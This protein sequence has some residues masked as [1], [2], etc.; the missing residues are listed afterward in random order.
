MGDRSC[1]FIELGISIMFIVNNECFVF[2]IILY[3]GKNIID[4]IFLGR[5]CYIY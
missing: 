2:G 3:G 4:N 1:Y 5:C